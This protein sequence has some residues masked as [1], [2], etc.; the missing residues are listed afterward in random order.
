M[1]LFRNILRIAVLLFSLC[2]TFFFVLDGCGGMSDGDEDSEDRDF[3]NN[4]DRR[5]RDRDRN[6]AR[7]RSED[8]REEDNLNGINEDEDDVE[9]FSKSESRWRGDNFG[10]DQVATTPASQIIEPLEQSS[11]SEKIDFL[12]VID[13]SLSNRKFIE[14]SVLQKK[15]GSF[16]PR[17]NDENIDWR[18]F[19]TCGHTDEDKP[20]YDGRLHEMEH[21][22]TLIN[23]LYLD[24]HILD[25]YNARD[26]L[27]FMSAVFID[28][29][30]H[31]NRVNCSRPPFCH[32]NT[33]NRPLKALSGFLN[34]AH[35]HQILRDDADMLVIIISNQDEQP[36][37][38]KPKKPY[39]P[40]KI[41]DQFEQSFPDK[42]LFAINFV[43][44]STDASC[45]KG[46]PA[47]FI[48]QLGILTNGLTESIC[49]NN[50]THTIIEFIREKQGK[51]VRRRRPVST[52]NTAEPENLRNYIYGD[53][54][55]LR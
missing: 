34:T 41:T 21:N 12:F 4:R 17:L 45:K 7:G 26:P 54:L 42:N 16:I 46:K 37:K 43:V 15:L 52:R 49:S 3:R 33:E 28:T 24:N 29:I 22:G 44:K 2:L 23:F 14:K 47:S 5:E 36:S 27:A 40:R 6:R 10:D 9:R 48:P 20:I 55:D 31:P 53:N 30:S 19:T 38:T 25:S 39:D 51:P 18:I 1:Y 8:L 13:T 50:Y 11:L 32:R 35:R